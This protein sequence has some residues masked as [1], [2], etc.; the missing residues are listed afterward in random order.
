[1]LKPIVSMNQMAMNESIATTCCY[2]WNGN[3]I[4][5]SATVLHGGKIDAH[6]KYGYYYPGTDAPDREKFVVSDGWL[7]VPCYYVGS[8]Y[9]SVLS[10]EHN[11]PYKSAGDWYTGL[12]AITTNQGNIVV[13]TNWVFKD[14]ASYYVKYK[15]STTLNH[16]GATSAHYKWT[17]G[18]NWLADHAAVQYSS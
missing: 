16:I 7:N 10:S 11:L 14:P 15:K 2:K 12:D 5:G 8:D 17:E 6:V 18:N 3:T 1:M 4:T 13:N 9:A